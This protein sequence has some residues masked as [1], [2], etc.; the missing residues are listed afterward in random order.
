[1]SCVAELTMACQRGGSLAGTSLIADRLPLPPRILHPRSPARQRRHHGQQRLGLLGGGAGGRVRPLLHLPPRECG[2]GSSER[3]SS[4]LAAAD[5]CCCCCMSVAG[6][7]AAAPMTA[8]ALPLT[9]HAVLRPHSLTDLRR[10]ARQLPG[11][12]TGPAQLP[13]GR[14]HLQARRFGV[15]RKAPV[16]LLPRAVLGAC[17]SRAAAPAS[18]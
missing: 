2:I 16:L 7:Q 8:R 10:Q 9:L 18:G 5:R 12:G 13:R 17:H 3:G 11:P 4:A 6:R 15:S 1:M 14:A